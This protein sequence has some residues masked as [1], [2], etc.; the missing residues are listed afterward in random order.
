M[1]FLSQFRNRFALGSV[2][3]E[4]HSFCSACTVDC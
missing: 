1:R 4:R 2:N 3:C